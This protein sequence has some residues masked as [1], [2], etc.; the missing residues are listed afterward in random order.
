MAPTV[1]IA[2]GGTAGHVVPALAV[3]D[4]LRAERRRG[5]LP[6][7]ARARRGA[8]RPR[9]RL[10]DR[11]PRRARARP[12]QPAE[13]RR[14][15]R[16]GG[17]RGPAR[18]ERV[19]RERGADV[20][21][22]GGGYVAGPAGP[23]RAALR[24]PLVLT[25]ADSH[26]GLANRLLARRARR[27]CLAFPIPGREGE[28]YLRH[29]PAGARGRARAPTAG[30]RASASGS[31]AGRAA[32]SSSAAASGARTIN[33]AALAAF[34]ESGAERDFRVLHIA[35]RRDYA[36]AARARGRGGPRALH[37]ARVRAEPR[38]RARGLRPRPRPLR[39]LGLRAG[40]GRAAR[41]S[42]SPT[43]T[44]PPTT[45]TPTPSGWR[46]AGRRE[47]D[48]GRRARRRAACATRSAELLA[49]GERLAEMAAAS[50]VAGPP[51][52]AR[53]DRRRGPQ[54]GRMAAHERLERP[55]SCTSSRSAAPG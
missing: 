45:S 41:R 27:V 11:L 21:M 31:P 47:V 37:A 55:R 4:A 13:R 12:R 49:D 29:R 5:L 25:E 50:R 48:R 26:L 52:A 10:R 33:E 6:R 36:E 7:H 18:R 43:R 54:R 9:G 19:L 8:A 44:R 51:D 22:G 38:R 16:A 17:A 15:G 30:R 3:A 46:E 14:R 42:S 34:A 32:C 20:V 39:R 1:V 2:A 23:R 28:R 53:A 35:G 24:L 40:R